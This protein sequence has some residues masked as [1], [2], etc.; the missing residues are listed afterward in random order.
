MKYSLVQEQ[1]A[2]ALDEGPHAS[3]SDAA[4]PPGH[5]FGAVNDLEASHNR[6]GLKSDGTGFRSVGVGGGC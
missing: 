2:A 6:G 5:S 3:G 1:H 4:E